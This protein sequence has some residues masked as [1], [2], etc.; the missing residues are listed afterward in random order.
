[1]RCQRIVTGVGLAAIAFLAACAKSTEETPSTGTDREADIAAIRSLIAQKDSTVTAGQAEQFM[2][3]LSDDIIWM[4]PN[5][6]AL[7]GRDAV[8]EALGPR[9]PDLN[10][11]HVGTV[12]ELRVAGDWAYARSSY[13]L[14]VTPKAGGDT[15]EEVGK[16]FYILGRHADGSWKITRGI[17]NSDHPTP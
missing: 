2:S 13:V 6:P 17:W 4:A 9:F 3:L 11:D 12:D 16:G 8:W 14:R 1:M 5:H 7:V 10:M 15:I